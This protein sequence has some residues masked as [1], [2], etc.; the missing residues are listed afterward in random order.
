MR[1]FHRTY[2]ADTIIRDGFRDGEGFYL[3]T[4]RYRGVWLS[5][6]PLDENEGAEGD[7]VLQVKIPEDVVSEY[8]WI[9]EGKPYREFLVP[10]EIIN[11]YGPPRVVIDD[12]DWPEHQRARERLGLSRPLL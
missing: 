6:R 7:I 8:E 12:R 3:T 9:E 11:R 2:Y 4:H 1:L 5:N 10:A